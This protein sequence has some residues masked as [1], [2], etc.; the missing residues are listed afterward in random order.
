MIIEDAWV[1]SD[2]RSV[3]SVSSDLSCN[4]TSRDAALLNIVDHF[5]IS[6]FQR[7]LKARSVLNGF[8]RISYL[9]LAHYFD[10]AKND[11]STSQT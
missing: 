1:G 3:F 4:L 11:N 8:K 9:V 10:D 7:K 6:D 5:L 2:D